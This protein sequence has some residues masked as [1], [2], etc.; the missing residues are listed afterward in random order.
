MTFGGFLYTVIWTL[1]GVVI[2]GIVYKKFATRRCKEVYYAGS[3]Q[4]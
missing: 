3:V 2:V 4:T 1:V